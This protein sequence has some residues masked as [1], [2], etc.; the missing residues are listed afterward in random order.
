MAAIPIPL[1]A[2]LEELLAKPS[3][4]HRTLDYDQHLID[5]IYA[6]LQ[7]L[8]DDGQKHAA[9]APVRGHLAAG[10]DDLWSQLQAHTEAEQGEREA[11]QS[12]IDSYPDEIEDHAFRA[13]SQ[14]SSAAQAQL[15]D[16]LARTFSD[17]PA[18]A[19]S[20]RSSVMA[21]LA[22]K[23][24]AEEASAELAEVLGFDQLDLVSALV[25]QREAILSDL[26]HGADRHRDGERRVTLASGHAPHQH[27]AG[28][29]AV[30]AKPYTPGSQVVVQS[31]EDKRLAKKLRNEMRRAN[32]GRDADPSSAAAAHDRAYT[33]EEL[34]QMREE[35]LAAAASR[36]L[37]SSDQVTSDEPRYPHVFSSGAHGNVLSVFGQRFALPAGTTRVEQSFYEEVTIPP[38]RNVPFRID[39]R[40]IPI[41]EMDTLSK[42]AF[43]GY[44]TLN[45]L[46][47]VVYPLAYRTNENL[48][49]CAPTGAGKTDVAMLTVLRAISQYAQS[50]DPVAGR[51]ADGFGIARDEF[52]IVYVAPMKALAAEVV[53][54]F[55]KRLQYLG[56]KV[57]ELTGDMQLTRKEIN[58]TQ[59]I[60]TTPE[61]WDVVTR[62]PTGDGELA[63]KVRLLIIDEVHLLHE[64]RGAVIETIVAR[65]LR[66][67]ESSQS[68]IRIVGLSATLPNY[69]DV[70]DF[71]RVNRYQG[72]FYF[73]S[74]FRPVPLEQ[75]F[76]G[77]KG[78]SGSPQA[79]ANLDKAAFEKVSELV[80]AG[81]Q[82]MVFVHARKETVKTAQT[83]RDMFKDEGLLDHLTAGRDDNPKL[84][85]FGKELQASRNKEMKELYETGFGIHHAGM[86]RSDRNVSERLFETGVTRVLCCTATLAW[87][88]NLPAYAVIIKGTDV[89]DSSA[90]KFVDLS[91]LDVLQ[92]FG[93]AGR[94]QYEDL[95]VGF[96]C[97]SQDRL[98]HYVDAITSQ[99]PIESKFIGGLVDSLNAEV[100]LGTVTSVRDGVSWLGY[101]YLFTRMKRT[102]L[103]YGMVHAEVEDDPHLGAK[104]L[105]LITSAAKKLVEAKML[106]HDATTGHLE[107]TEMGRV[108]AKYYV[109]HRTIEVFNEKLRPRMSEADVLG[110]LSLATDFEQII[111]RDTEERELKKMLENAPCQVPGGIETSPGKVNILLQAYISRTY[112]E[113]F[114]LVSDSAY[115]A[116]NAG[117]IIRSLL[118]IALSNKWA[119]TTAALMAMSKAIER[120]MWPFDHPLSQSHLTPDTLY[121]LTRWADEVEVAELAEMS[122]NE[123][124]RLVHLNERMGSAIRSAARS[125]PTLELE[126]A[127]RPLTHG[128][129]RIDLRIRRRFE[130]NERLH[131]RSEAFYVWVEDENEVDILQWA[132]HVVR[133]TEAA[134]SALS[135]TVPVPDPQPSGISVRWIS[136]RWIGAEDTVWVPFDDLAMPPRPA[137]HQQLLDLP[138]LPVSSAVPDELLR[139]LY[140]QHMSGFNALQ[141]QSFHT[142][143]HTKANA[144]LCAP[145][146]SGKSTVAFFAAWRAMR[147]TPGKAVLVLYPRRELVEA[148]LRGTSAAI[149]RQRDVD[150]VRAMSSTS[151]QKALS[152]GKRDRVI[153]AAPLPWLRALSSSGPKLLERVSLVIAEDLH[154]LDA[155]YELV[156]SRTLWASSLCGAPVRLV[157]TS[158]SLDDAGSL[159]EWLGVKEA[160]RYSFDPRDRPS[161]LGMSFRTFD[162]PHSAGL[163][164]TMVKPAYDKMKET[165]MHGPT[166]IFVPSHG[167]CLGVASDL[168][169]RCASELDTEAFISVPSHDLE[170]VLGSIRDHSLHEALMHGFGVVHDGLAPQDRASV[171]QLFEQG[172]IKVLVASRESCWTLPARAHLVIVMSTQYVRLTKVRGQTSISDREVVDYSM[173]ELVRMQ[174][175]AVRP[176][177]P[178]TPSPSGEMLVL[179]QSDKAALL[180]RLLPSG[181]PLQS[182][183]LDD[184]AKVLLPYLLQEIVA[185]AAVSR[186]DMLSLLTWT[187]VAIEAQR[188]P[189]YYDVQGTGPDAASA[190]LSRCVDSLLDELEGLR[191]VRSVDAR[192][193]EDNSGRAAGNLVEVTN[194]GR[195]LHLQ[196]G[197]TVLHVA[198]W[199]AKMSGKPVA[200]AAVCKKYSP[201]A[202]S[203]SKGARDGPDDPAAVAV[204]KATRSIVPGDW[205]AAF[206]VPRGRA[207]AARSAKA[208]RSPAD[209]GADTG[210]ESINGAQRQDEPGQSDAKAQEEGGEPTAEAEFTAAQRASLLLA[211]WFAKR[212]LCTTSEALRQK[213]DR[214]GQKLA[215]AAV[216]AAQQS[217][218]DG[219]SVFPD[220]RQQMAKDKL[221]AE[222]ASAILSLLEAVSNVE[223]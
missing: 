132:M 11:G 183:L 75:H 200:A 65:T 176:G 115:V 186:T 187:F 139:T 29:R 117:R 87:G 150:V 163:L 195:A 51:G 149:A 71:L 189:S 106:K 171:L 146:A 174:A 152:G 173:P 59:M 148:A 112:V 12:A 60:V 129:L 70:A 1:G 108:A 104:R 170:S 63:T 16:Y 50:I 18:I 20:I 140:A 110:I 13:A 100:S 190:R 53:R 156:I 128:L 204:L 172:I 32:R 179:C 23:G 145:S 39:E 113:D 90:G 202:R 116:Q 199:H 121:N 4:S 122:A 217:T 102:P 72:L 7:K 19:T 120:R 103:T 27:Q 114:A 155:T 14:P 89:Y 221:E 85:S 78:K 198:R 197:S 192:A 109:G 10:G 185:G 220:E 196:P 28:L 223:F 97:T 67:V 161:S 47:S 80:Q 69:V 130:W 123:V 66:L 141:T 24:S 37:F 76:I 95:G 160:A 164:K 5:S 17:D 158:A 206:G 144:L 42:G 211:A 88:V 214:K 175:H 41:G 138:L 168:V 127:L 73:D 74:S 107:V 15:D 203:T 101:T 215:A 219:S 64:E 30:A 61:K 137:K 49:V 194:L 57:R 166:I 159:A 111:P 167:Q 178:S 201:Q 177:T 125:F 79:R 26:A 31:Q 33:L 77:V 36:P 142:I 124:G 218:K 157:G 6:S 68:L 118:E 81:H 91:I 83:L 3:G 52:K 180:E 147:E 210:A 86:L 188:N 181:L 193:S 135:F 62:K 40:L 222:Q 34:E 82:V 133:P 207:S 213:S 84:A 184:D 43:P 93:R 21:A 191:L 98:S 99:H 105:Q 22:S 134:Y 38:P 209:A 208:H 45:R 44:K 8:Q 182:S 151:L 35:S 131:G 216:A 48:L 143:A 55:S 2:H 165:A 96:I 92:I 169:T 58:E 212:P 9:P 154:L 94:P 153:F 25:S 136:D 56:I 46:Q 205:L 119:P 54:K 162:L 126:A